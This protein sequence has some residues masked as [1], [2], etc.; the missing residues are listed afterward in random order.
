MAVEI[1]RDTDADSISVTVTLDVKL[2]TFCEIGKRQ[3][4]A[5][6]ELEKFVNMEALTD[7]QKAI[8][9][10]FTGIQVDNAKVDL[11]LAAQLA[12]F[13]EQAAKIKASRPVVSGALEA[14]K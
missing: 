10:S 14:G 13:T 11:D 5:G 1:V 6:A 8:Q 2:S 4:K 3:N 12:N 9:A 7:C